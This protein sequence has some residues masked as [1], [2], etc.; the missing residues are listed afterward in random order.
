MKVLFLLTL[1]STFC[2]SFAIYGESDDVLL[3]V[4]TSRAPTTKQNPDGEDTFLDRITNA[5][6][7]RSEILPFEKNGVKSPDTAKTRIFDWDSTY[8]LIRPT[9]PFSV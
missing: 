4:L 6:S 9:R 5:Q 7:P 3:Q 8:Q 1:V 2:A